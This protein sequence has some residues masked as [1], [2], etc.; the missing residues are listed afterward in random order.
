VIALGVIVWVFVLIDRLGQVLTRLD[1]LSS[2]EASVKTDGTPLLLLRGD[3][4]NS[5]ANNCR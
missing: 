3:A 5:G 1:Q 4:H 2:H